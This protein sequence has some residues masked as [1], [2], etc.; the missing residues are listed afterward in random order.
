MSTRQKTIVA[1]ATIL[2][3]FNLWKW[4]P[5]EM[6]HQGNANG[7]I[8]GDL[9]R[10]DDVRLRLPSEFNGKHGIV[11]RN[12]FL[13]KKRTSKVANTKSAPIAKTKPASTPIDAVKEAAKAELNRIKFVG[14]LVQNSK[15]QAFL[16][17][18][19]Q[20]FLVFVGDKIANRY[21]V[22]QI[23]LDHITLIDTKTDMANRIPITGNSSQ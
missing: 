2:I 14:I 19:E 23:T 9:T 18:D 13:P 8:P 21:L 17:K 12:L 20:T 10:V 22:E 5:R 7:T 15:K 6:N 11:L 1:I 4:W 16:V 3:A